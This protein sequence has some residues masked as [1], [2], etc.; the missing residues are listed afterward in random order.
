MKRFAILALVSGLLMG[1]AARRE[2]P[3]IKASAWL[4]TGGRALKM[5][6]M[7]GKVVV[8]PFISGFC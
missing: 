1:T 2:T 7:R 4:N 8:L 6:D 3:E 5:A